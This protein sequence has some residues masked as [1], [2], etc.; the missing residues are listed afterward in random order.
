MLRTLNIP[1]FDTWTARLAGIAFFAILTAISAKIS[2]P[3]GFVPITMQPFVVILA[4]LVLG[5]RDGAASLITY[6]LMIAWGA[7]VDTNSLG[8]AAFFGPTGGY[9]IGFVFAAF[10]TGWLVEAGADK[11][12]QRWLA[13]LVGVAIIYAFGV[14][15]LKA[16]MGIDW[17]MT[18]Q[19]GVMPFIVLDT[20]KAL[21][22]AGM[23]ESTRAFLLRDSQ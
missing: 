20:I 7:P 15:V 9:L 3:T 8:T 12:W 10:A 18:I 22:A 16:N 23:V 17:A 2:I 11:V 1:R 21:I 6:L 4:G 13:G 5:S 14:P 19:Y